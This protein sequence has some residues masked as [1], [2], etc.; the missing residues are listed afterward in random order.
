MVKSGAWFPYSSQDLLPLCYRCSTTNPLINSA[1]NQCI[2]CRQPFEF[3]FVSF[4]NFRTW[5]EQFIFLGLVAIMLAAVSLHRGPTYSWVCTG[6]GNQVSASWNWCFFFKQDFSI[7]PIFTNRFITTT[8]CWYRYHMT[9]F[10]CVVKS[11]RFRALKVNYVFNYCVIVYMY[12]CVTHACVL[13][14]VL[15]LQYNAHNN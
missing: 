9:S 6:R 2:C 3:S 1:G 15:H 11:L 4:G 12:T 5:F 13:I 7:L 14:N 10:N 8:S